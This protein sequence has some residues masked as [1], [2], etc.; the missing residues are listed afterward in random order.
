MS[1]LKEEIEMLKKALEL[2]RD[3]TINWGQ[4]LFI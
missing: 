1:D 3:A 2:E 4:R